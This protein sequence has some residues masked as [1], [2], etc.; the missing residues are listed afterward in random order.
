VTEPERVNLWTRFNTEDW[1][2]A[3]VTVCSTLVVVASMFA[4]PDVFGMVLTP[5]SSIVGTVFFVWVLAKF[6]WR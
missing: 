6:F 3:L 1:V 4:R 5:V 2:L